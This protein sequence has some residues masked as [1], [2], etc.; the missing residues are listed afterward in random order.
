MH[1]LNFLPISSG[2]GLQ[3]SLSFL[4][5]LKNKTQ[6]FIF[7]RHDS[8]IELYCKNN[9]IQYKSIKKGM[10]ARLKFEL[11][12]FKKYVK[13]GD[14]CFTFFGPPMLGSFNYLYN[15]AGCAYSNL[16]YEEID[17]WGYLP[18]IQQYKKKLIDLYRLFSIS[19]CDEVI[20]ETCELKKRAALRYEFRDIKLHVV[21]MAVSRLIND[22]SQITDYFSLS[23]VSGYKFL[24]LCGDQPNKRVYEFL[25]ILCE[26]NKKNEFKIVLTMRKSIYLSKILNKASILGISDKIINLGNIQPKLVASAIYFSDSVV[27][28]ARL[29]SFSNNFIEAW[30][31]KKLLI[32]TDADWARACCGDSAVYIEPY[33]VNF[34]CSAIL[35]GISSPTDYI[36]SGESLLSKHPT[37]NEKNTLYYNIIER[38]AGR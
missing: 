18:V 20:F 10:K 4:H 3:N 28:I 36:S 32:V 1:I 34:A 25:D 33:N 14:V 24:F 23:E 15:I 13:K 17:F 16:F 37:P 22:N 29:E 26:L 11:F 21:N 35:Q 2:G 6:Y 9:N 8:E 7:C 19:K 31:L 12:G 27:N 30:S 38:A 5:G